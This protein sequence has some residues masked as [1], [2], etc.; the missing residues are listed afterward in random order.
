MERLDRVVA[1]AEWSRSYQRAQCIHGLPIGS[2]NA[3]IV[4]RFDSLERKGR[5]SFRVEAMWFEK[6]EVYDV[7]KRAWR[8][9]DRRPISEAYNNKMQRC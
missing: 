3:P 1:N 4:L 8:V 2:D 7:I 5:K 6:P 9:Q